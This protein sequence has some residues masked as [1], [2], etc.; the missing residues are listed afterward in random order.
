MSGRALVIES[1]ATLAVWPTPASYST[2]AHNNMFISATD[3]DG[4]WTGA[5][6]SHFTLTGGGT[7]RGGGAAW[8]PI[9]ASVVRPRILW[10]PNGAFIT[11]SN[12]KLVDSPAW[13]MGLRGSNILVTDM[14]VVSGA[15]SCG[16][17]GHAPNTDGVN[18]GGHD[19]TVRNVTVHNGDDCVPITTGPDG[20]SSNILV[21]DVSCACGTNG[22]VIYNEGGTVAGVTA[23][24]ITVENTNQGA[25][26]K[27]ARPGRDATAGRVTNITFEDVTIAHPRYAAL[28]V[29][30]F[31]EDAQPP[32]V[33]PA[34]HDL[35]NWLTVRNLSFTRVTATVDDGQTAGCFRCTPGA[36]CSATFDGVSVRYA[37]GAVARDFVCL[38]MAGA[39]GAGGSSP[40]A[41]AA[42]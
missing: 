6:L 24:R 11:V 36:P 13:N 8:W 40:A 4:S 5:L 33:L 15:D 1:G 21:E 34:N 20:T 22:V 19:I 27:L 9:A 37:S 25:G 2:T 35:K 30:V 7:V 31:Q 10:V 39:T 23:R 26:V 3:G 42:A 17:F 32:C 18:L 29:N 12:L 16:G 14:R 41:C 28:Y 38:N